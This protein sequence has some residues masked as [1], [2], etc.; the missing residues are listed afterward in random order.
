MSFT[1][2][3]FVDAGAPWP[4]PQDEPRRTRYQK[5]KALWEGDH[6][7]VF[8]HWWRVLREDQNASLQLIFNWHKRLACLW[9]DLMLSE[10][11]R[12]QD[13]HDEETA[14][15]ASEKPTEE[16]SDAKPT[17]DKSSK[18][19]P[20]EPG[21]PL[22]TPMAEEKAKQL[23]AKKKA[24]S[25]RQEAIDRITGKDDNGFVNTLYE[26][27]IDISRFGNGL[28]KITLG[29]EG[30]EIWAQP[31]TYWFPVTFAHNL[32][33]IKNHV[34]AWE[35]EQREARTNTLHK[36]LWMEIHHKGLIEYRVH[37]LNGNLIGERLS[38][39][40]FDPDQ[41]DSE[42][43]GL[44]DEFLVVPYTGLQASDEL[45][46]NDDYKDL[47]TIVSAI[48]LRAAQ[49]N[50]VLDKHTDPSVYGPPGQLKRN[51]DTGVME[52]ASGGRYIEVEEDE[53]PPAYLV[54]EAQLDAQ[55]Q[56]LEFLLEQLFV[57]SMT[58]PAAFGQQKEGMAESGSA[59]RRLLMCPLIKVARL[60]NKFGPA[61]KHTLRI[62]AKLEAANGHKTP[63]LEE[64]K[65]E[66]QDGLPGD[67]L[68]LA[69][70]EQIRTKDTPTSS[71]ISSI[72]RLDG[73]TREDAEAEA[74]RI[75]EEGQLR[76]E[77]EL[78]SALTQTDGELSLAAKHA[79]PEASASSSS[80]PK[81]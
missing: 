70:A 24:K 15:P 63:P 31:P 11:P 32:R 46:G 47:D 36:Y 45:Y 53:V 28:A 50:R 5:N 21:L 38:V 48:E 12:F 61:V 40:E 43:T 75:A 57:V 22:K 49:I 54:W 42:E 23:E 60:T 18:P 9:A 10:P 26:I 1:D 62:A 72:Q 44:D 19:A 2:L 27:A 20:F 6:D 80:A 69:Q 41:V 79:P 37:R 14:D 51:P 13:G 39:K 68:E 25:P 77:S 58:S 33:K 3:Q 59:L 34:L 64:I 55:F 17:Q 74:Q 76:A 8:G 16:N 67:P 56:E 29:E 81:K 30:A 78:A 65:I 71:V 73:G 4:P 66:W 35:F 52:F 7:E